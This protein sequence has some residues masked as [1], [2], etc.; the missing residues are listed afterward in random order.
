MEHNSCYK[1][2]D[3]KKA[4]QNCEHILWDI[5]V[6]KI[7]CNHVVLTD[8]V[9]VVKWKRFPHYWSFVRGIHWQPVDSHHK[10]PS[11]VVLWY[12]HC[13]RSKQAVE[14]TADLT[15]MWHNCNQAAA[16]LICNNPTKSRLF[17]KSIHTHKKIIWWLF[18]K[19]IF[20][21]PNKPLIQAPN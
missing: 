10:G 15:L 4:Q 3:T 13:S 1:Q 19:S 20:Y 21:H 17:R 14:P 6:R 9:D 18:L 8:R 2:T 16:I 5:L 12:F 11:N 7:Q